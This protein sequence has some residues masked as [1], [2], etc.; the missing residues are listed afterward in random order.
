MPE[1]ASVE[2]LESWKK[3]GVAAGL[4]APMLVLLLSLAGSP[5]AA[6]DGDD[7]LLE[8]G[9][10]LTARGENLLGPYSRFPFN[11]PGP[12]Y[13]YLMLP[14]Y[15]L[16]GQSNGS[17]FLTSALLNTAALWLIC[18]VVRPRR[19]AAVLGVGILTSLLLASLGIDRLFSAWNPNVPVLAFGAAVFAFAAA[20]A[21][22][23]VYLAP[24]L[25]LATLAVQ[26][27]LAYAAPA[28]FVGLA[29]ALML[30]FPRVV[31][32][33]AKPRL[34]WRV[35]MAASA[36]PALLW[37]PAL[38]QEFSSE[39]GNISKLVAFFALRHE[40]P[41]ASA[42][43]EVLGERLAGFLPGQSP[44]NICLAGI[45]V[46]SLPVAYVFSLRRGDALSA[47]LSLLSLAGVAG[48]A[49]GTIRIVGPIS[50]H[51]LVWMPTLG[52]TGFSALVTALSDWANAP[53][54]PIRLTAGVTF[55]LVFLAIALSNIR[56]AW[57]PGR[58]D[59][60]PNMP[61][62]RTIAKVAQA[63]GAELRGSRVHYPEVRIATS[64]SWPMAA[65]TLLRLDKERQE[66][67]VEDAWLFQYGAALACRRP[68][69]GLLI[70]GDAAFRSRVQGD[71]RF[72]PIAEWD[73]GSVFLSVEVP[74]PS[75]IDFSGP[76]SALYLKRGFTR[77]PQLTPGQG[78]WSIGPSS[79]LTLPLRPETSH[80][81]EIRARPLSIPGRTQIIRLFLN[82]S[83][84]TEFPLVDRELDYMIR[85]PAAMVRDVNELRFEYAYFEP[86]MLHSKESSDWRPLGVFFRRMRIFPVMKARQPGS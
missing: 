75:A 56:D 57:V 50:D 83:L 40:G 80:K 51:L 3:S 85:A 65:G 14:L 46:L 81:L 26:S 25:V 66:F 9:V 68:T 12:A 58:L 43:A 44:F 54:R 48:A 61:R 59:D 27:H 34:D 2:A 86:P 22:R 79:S 82:G 76:E 32:R 55:S 30:L 31:G 77:L 23:T 78:R 62:H 72:R 6:V 69:D 35:V 64:I 28:A 41:T 17:F 47:S 67:C 71:A 16:R 7:A 36:L 10:R 39:S 73:E 42:T 74:P 8:L 33:S 20:A 63:T 60:W 18:R 49:F 29:A 21:G 19:W 53:G 37:L 84:L 5:D 4:L 15:L 1:S 13:F 38:Y 11:H 70:F 52:L 45:L 24:A